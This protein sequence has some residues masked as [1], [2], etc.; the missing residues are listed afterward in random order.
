VIDIRE[1]EGGTVLRVRVQPRA[2]REEIAGE[3]EG[4][5]L[6]RLTTPPVEGR[7]NRALTALMARALDVPPSS[8]TVLRGARGRDKLVHVAGVPEAVVRARL[9]AA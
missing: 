6:V 3:R 4:A 9:G 2:S 8:V 1:A 5:L 7:A